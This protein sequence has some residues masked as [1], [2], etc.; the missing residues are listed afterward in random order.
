MDAA[1]R[2]TAMA[3][4]TPVRNGKESK[5]LLT[6]RERGTN[7]I[8]TD[9]APTDSSITASAL[10]A[11]VKHKVDN[12]CSIWVEPLQ[13]VVINPPVSASFQSPRLNLVQK[14]TH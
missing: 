6:T 2:A 10:A 14:N 13:S 7:L 4:P 1:A 12:L 3:Q 9:Q 11:C 5:V 8:G